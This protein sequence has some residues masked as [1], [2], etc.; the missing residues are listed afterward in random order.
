MESKK[1]LIIDDE[2]VSQL[3]IAARLRSNGY[4]VVSAGD[5]VMATAVAKEE[6][7][8]LILLDIGLPGGD[9]II[10]MKRIASISTIALTPIIIIT[11][12]DSPDTQKRAFENGA[13]AFFQK[14][15]DFDKLLEAIQKVLGVPTSSEA[16]SPKPQ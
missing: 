3:T 14:P 10:V 1:I 5:A 13:V 11:A 7:P 2:R 16:V 6:K 9:G 12:G 4:K 15:V 8:D